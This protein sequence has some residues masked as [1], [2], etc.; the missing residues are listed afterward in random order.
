MIKKFYSN[1]NRPGWKYDARLKKYCSW[2]FEMWLATG[3][4]KRETGFLNRAD[5]ESVVVRIRQLEKEMKYGLVVTVEAP[6]LEETCAKKL[7]LTSSRHE[8]VRARRVL[9]YFRRVAG[10]KRITEIKTEHM[11]RFVDTRRREVSLSSVDRELN[12]ISGMLHSAAIHFPALSNWTVPAV[13]WPK[14]SK[15]RR[16][17]VIQG[18]ELVR[19]LNVL[20]APRGERET[21]IQA[22]NRKNAGHVFRFASLSGARKGEICKLRWS[23]VLW[24][25]GTVQIV[26]TKTENRSAQTTRTLPLIPALAE[27][28]RDRQKQSKGAYVFTRN[29]GEVTHYYS[30]IRAACDKAGVAYGKDTPGGFVTH[31][32]RHTAV[33]RML[34]DGNDLA[35][36]GSITGQGDKTMVMLYGHASPASIS[37]AMNALENYAGIQAL[38]DDLETDVEDVAFYGDNKQGLVPKGGRV[39]RKA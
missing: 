26:G 25:S 19:V 22:A 39:R 37:R 11:Q 38:G 3:K 12:I 2:G 36:I 31:D 21:A 34:Q 35:T 13:P 20:Y 33:T 24:D 15:R 5:V 14:H 30:I 28:L 18:S 17:R 6:T 32:A 8:L 9:A 7:S 16:E 10:V 29:G 23:H 27:I 4:R 1:R